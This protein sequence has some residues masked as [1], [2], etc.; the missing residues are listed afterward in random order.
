[1][2][3]SSPYQLFVGIDVAATTFT[4]SWSF[5][6]DS[7]G[8]AVTLPQTPGGYA[9][10]QQRLLASSREPSATLIVLEA[11][12]SYWVALAVALH[13][14]GFVVSVV[15]PVHVVNYAKSR[16]R[17]AKTDPRDAQ[18]L[19]HFAVERQPPA[20]T[21]PPQVYHEL[22]QRLVARDAL[23]EMRQH[24]RNHRHA[25]IQWPVQVVAVKAQ[26]DAIIDDLDHRIVTLE[27]EITDVLHAGAWAESAALLL[28]IHSVGPL[29]T[30]WVLVATLNFEACAT[31][32]SAVAYAGLAPLVRESGTSVRGRARIGHG[33]NRRLRTA[34][35][36]ATLNA[37]RFNPLIKTFYERLRA[38]G[39]PAKVAR[40]AAARKLLQIAWAVVVKRTPFDVERGRVSVV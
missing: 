32:A 20:W 6:A 4:V 22:R 25:F 10:L 33:G 13:Q 34:L 19:V 29:T 23:V 31:A 30:A 21:P 15:H 35:Y 37:T 17:R 24:A 18:L 38:A 1:M 8:K 11:T 28:T 12:G 40:C 3:T 14:A 16:T 7:P 27:R 39:K 26:L 9:D 5:D 2:R 36:Q